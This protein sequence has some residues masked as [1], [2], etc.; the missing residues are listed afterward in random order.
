M[1]HSE[2]CFLIF[3]HEGFLLSLFPLMSNFSISPKD[4][5]SVTPVLRNLLNLSYMDVLFLLEI[6]YIHLFCT[7][8]IRSSLTF[9]LSNFTA[10]LLMKGEFKTILAV[11]LSTSP[12]VPHILSIFALN[13]LGFY[14]FMLQLL[15]FSVICSSSLFETSLS[16]LV[17]FKSALHE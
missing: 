12:H 14:S 9:I 1:N 4:I 5:L 7:R 6:A 2:V 10:S 11:T 13:V 16:F 8:P 3:K 15:H 17:V